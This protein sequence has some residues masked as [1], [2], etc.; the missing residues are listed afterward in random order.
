MAAVSSL[1][2]SRALAAIGGDF[3]GAARGKDAHLGAGVKGQIR[4]CV[5]EQV[6]KAPVLD[7]Y[8]IHPQPGGGSCGL[9]GRGQLPV[10]QENV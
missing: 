8:R 1:E 2:H 9:Q 4:Q 3:P 7:Q 10:R 6:K 5:P